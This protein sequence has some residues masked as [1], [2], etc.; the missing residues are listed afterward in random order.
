MSEVILEIEG[1]SGPCWVCKRTLIRS[2]GCVK[3]VALA[4]ASPPKYHLD[5][6]CSL[7]DIAVVTMISLSDPRNSNPVLSALK[8]KPQDKIISIR[9]NLTADSNFILTHL[10]K[11]ILY[12]KNRLCLVSFHNPVEHYQYVGKKLGYDLLKAVE[13]NV[14]KIVEPISDIVENIGLEENYL[15]EDKENLVKCFYHDIKRCLSDISTEETQ[16]YLMVDDLS[17]LLDLGVDLSVII[18]FVNYCV[19]FINNDRVSVV[20]NSHVSSKIDEI[21]ANNLQYIADVHI[22][23]SPL[24]TGRSTDVTGFLTVERSTGKSR[25]HYKAFDRGDKN[26]PSR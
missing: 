15:Q 12:E 5:T 23:V 21:I 19:N 14:V 20:L 17:H 6:L 25:Y 7:S 18:N 16:T 1:F 22:E 11:Q 13:D 9:E 10:I 26:F 24:N 2:S 4:A 3:Q 8:I